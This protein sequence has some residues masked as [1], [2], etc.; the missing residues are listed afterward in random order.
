MLSVAKTCPAFPAR[1]W[2]VS[3]CPPSLRGSCISSVFSEFSS[4]SVDPPPPSPP[5]GSPG[6]P[7]LVGV[8]TQLS[9]SFCWASTV[10]PAVMPRK[11]WP[12]LANTAVLPCPRRSEWKGALLMF[13][14]CARQRTFGFSPALSPSHARLAGVECHRVEYCML[15][16]TPFFFAHLITLLS[17]FLI[18]VIFDSCPYLLCH[19]F[20]SPPYSTLPVFAL[21]IRG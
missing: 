10:L 12:T 21:G 4:P 11:W 15:N 8:R 13:F 6:P 7:M 16:F 1:R 18:L 2:L 9:R 19:L 3:G 20:F 14:N 5:P 17:P